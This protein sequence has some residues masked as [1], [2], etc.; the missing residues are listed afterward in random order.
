M[1]RGDNLFDWYF[2]L[3]AS[4]GFVK[5]AINSC[6]ISRQERFLVCVKM[7]DKFHNSRNKKEDD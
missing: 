6:E 4:Q 1:F 3:L 5:D 2:L 7:K